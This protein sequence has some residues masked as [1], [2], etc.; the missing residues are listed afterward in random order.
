MVKKY[1]VLC[2]H[3]LNEIA[4][5][6]QQY[7]T[8]NRWGSNGLVWREFEIHLDC[9]HVWSEQV[10]ELWSVDKHDARS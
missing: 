4:V 2:D 10:P 7:F 1:V 5:P 9:L 8:V 6:G 3:C